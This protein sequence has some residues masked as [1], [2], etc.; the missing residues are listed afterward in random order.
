[1]EGVDQVRPILERAGVK[2]VHLAYFVDTIHLDVVFGLADVWVGVVDP[3]KLHYNTIAYL[4]KKGIEL[5]QVPPEEANKFAC[6]IFAIEPGKVVIP[7]GCPKTTKALKERGVTVIDS[8]FSDFIKMEG[9][10]HCCVSSLIR[11]PGPSLPK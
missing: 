7:A 10:P 11:D 5:I 1:M 3:R 2:E 8:E 4:K 9:G 6:N